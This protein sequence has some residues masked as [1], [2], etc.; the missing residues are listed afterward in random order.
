MNSD[1]VND[2]DERL[3]CTRAVRGEILISAN[4]HRGS[5]KESELIDERK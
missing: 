3:S 2:R 1:A 4:V 5:E